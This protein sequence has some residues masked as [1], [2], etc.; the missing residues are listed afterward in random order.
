MHN[1]FEGIIQHHFQNRWKWDFEKFQPMGNK[2]QNHDS[3][4]DFEMQ[5]DNT[6]SQSG[7]SWE[8]THNMISAF[9]NVRV[10]FGVTCI[11]QWLGQAKEGKIKA[12]KWNS[13]FS[14]YLPLAE[15]DIFLEDI[16]KLSANQ[17]KAVKTCLLVENLAALVACTHI[18][19]Q[20]LIT[21]A[22]FLS[23]EEEY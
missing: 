5:D 23:F 7:I 16:E 19:E 14:I 4:D 20:K 8:Q 12:S 9:S 10:P 15:I 18:L 21:V 13:L 2:S 1:W 3:D 17:T 6:L 22:N 11:P